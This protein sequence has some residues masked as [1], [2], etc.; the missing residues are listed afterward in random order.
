MELEFRTIYD[1]VINYLRN[2]ILE[3]NM[4]PGEPIDQSKIAEQINVSRTPIRQ[5]MRELE[6]EGLVVLHPHSVGIVAPLTA[7]EA[8]ELYLMRYG[9]EEF[10]AKEGA[11]KIDEDSLRQLEEL[12]LRMDYVAQWGQ[13][14]ATVKEYYQLDRRFHE[15]HYA[16]ANK[17]LLW[18]RVFKLRDMCQ[19]YTRS[20]WNKPES[21]NVTKE[22]HFRILDACKKHDGRAASQSIREDLEY[23]L[24]KLK[25]NM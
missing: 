9:L 6:S 21:T 2:E 12:Y 5:A 1:Y 3:G 23:T 18:K 4:K 13:T 14:A 19:R 20:Y 11:E 15:I 24:M 7:E 8:E 16:A 10:L 17:P 22:T 25:E